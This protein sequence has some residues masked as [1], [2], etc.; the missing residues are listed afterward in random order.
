[1]SWDIESFVNRCNVCVKYRINPTEPLLQSTLPH[2]SWQKVAYDLFYFNNCVYLL[3]IDYFLRWVEL[4]LL[5]RG[6]TTNDIMPHLKSMFAKFGIPEAVM[7][8]GGLQFSS[9]AFQNFA[10]HYVLDHTLSNLRYALNNRKVERAVQT[11]NNLFKKSHDSYLALSAYLTSPLRSGHSPAELSMSRLLH[12]RVPI[13]PSTFEPKWSFLCDFRKK[14]KIIKQRKKFNYDHRQ[15]ARNLPQL[16]NDSH[17]FIDDGYYENLRSR[18]LKSTDL[19]RSY[20]VDIPDR[21]SVV[22]NCKF[23]KPCIE[24]SIDQ[25]VEISNEQNRNAE[26]NKDE[27][28]SDVTRSGRVLKPPQ[29]LN[30]KF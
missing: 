5:N 13:L 17:E 18:V 8:D 30:Y 26:N 1:M 2:C 6:L 12:T 21:G 29:R 23:L 3:I 10:K 4:A 20:V 16:K 27:A 11:V 9:F 24:N 15:N 28:S 25:F 7:S 22:Q 19:P 14:E